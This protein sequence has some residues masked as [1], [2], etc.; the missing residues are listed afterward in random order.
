M[1]NEAE[2]IVP[3]YGSAEFDP[4][5]LEAELC[6][7]L[8]KL[9]PELWSESSEAAEIQLQNLISH[10][11]QI[12]FCLNLSSYAEVIAVLPKGVRFP[13]ETGWEQDQNPGA[14]A[15]QLWD[16]CIWWWRMIGTKSL[17]PS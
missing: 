14:D 12:F 9:G 4:E 8:A 16:E 5:T 11:I 15:A 17:Y 3:S 13:P 10:D 7:F 6:V 1:Y 2:A